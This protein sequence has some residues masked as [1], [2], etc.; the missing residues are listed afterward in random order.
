MCWLTGKT[1][2]D[3]VVERS[4]DGRV[5]WRQWER[6]GRVAAGRGGT[7]W[8]SLSWVIHH[9]PPFFS[10]FG[11]MWHLL[12]PCHLAVRGSLDFK[13]C[14]QLVQVDTGHWTLRHSTLGIDCFCPVRRSLGKAEL[15]DSQRQA[16]R[17]APSPDMSVMLETS[18][19]E[20]VID[21]EVDKCPK[22]CENFL[23]LCKVKYYAL[24]AFFNGAQG[25]FA[26]SAG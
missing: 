16:P 26:I 7:K 22:T 9:S 5:R 24:N 10:A 25:S 1:E 23:K 6:G 19:G 13:G 21:L 18:L 15:N 11:P 14:L 3:P 20:L 12:A 4:R 8:Q 17:R 2:T